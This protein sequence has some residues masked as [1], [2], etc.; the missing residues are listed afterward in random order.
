MTQIGA[1][2]Q[3]AHTLHYSGHYSGQDTAGCA[4]EV[5][6]EIAVNIVYAGVPYAVM[7]ASPGDLEDFATGF[8]LTEGVVLE[9]A[10]IRGIRME[11]QG[12][13]ILV[14]VD[15]IPA[16]LHRHLAR[17]RSL[18]GR[19]SCGLCGIESLDQVPA[20]GG[21]VPLSAPIVPAAIQRALVGLE[22]EQPLNRATHGVHAAAWC[23]GAGRIVLVREDVGRHNALDKMVG[24][25]LRAGLLARDGFVLLT[26]RCSFEMI[27]KSA[28]FGAGTVVA[29]SAPTSLAIDRAN[30]LGVTLIAVARRDG[31]LRFTQ[32]GSAAL[33]AMAS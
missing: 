3:V 18:G 15:L 25:C 16:A 14:H 5:P 9:I 26:S 22:A 33:S 7:M 4:V 27:E 8:S 2:S 24:G 19:T 28:I 23:D 11:P 21:L 1:R 32:P 20:A 13:G 17:K 10:E 6:V 31:A 12:D 30:S 29:I